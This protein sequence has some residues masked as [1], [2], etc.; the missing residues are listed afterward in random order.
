[1]KTNIVTDISSPIPNVAKFWFSR[2]DQNAVS[3][4]NCRIFKMYYLKEEVNDEVYF[5]YADKHRSLLQVDTI[6]FGVCNQAFPKNS[7]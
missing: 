4:S 2:Y 5:W 6:I 7:E 1:M 3:Q